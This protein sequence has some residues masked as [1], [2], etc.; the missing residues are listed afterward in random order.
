M[1]I[2][3]L[4]HLDLRSVSELRNAILHKTS[5]GSATHAAGKIIYDSGAVYVSDGS[6]WFDLSGDI[7]QVKVIG[8]DGN[9]NA[10]DVTSGNFVLTIAGASGITT[11][12]S[13]STLSI[14]L[15]DTATDMTATNS[16]VYGSST[17][18][19]VITVDR[20][21]RLTN[22]TTTSIS[23]SFT[24]KDDDD[25][26][27]V[28][29]MGKEIKFLG[30]GI[31]IDWT[32]T[33]AGTD[34]DPYD[35]TFT[36]SDKGSS[37]NIFKTVAIN[38]SHSGTLTY[39]STRNLEAD[40]NN[41]TLKVFDGDGIDVTGAS[42]DDIMKIAVDST[43]VRTSG[44]QT[45]AGDKTFSDEVIINGNLTV[46]GTQTTKASETVLIE[47]NIITL[48]SNETSAA[49]ENAGI[50]VERGSDTNVLLRWTEGTDRWQFTND[51]STYYNIPIPSEYDN[52]SFSVNA[53]NG[54]GQSTTQEVA[55]GGTLSFQA[56]VVDATDGIQLIISGD[57]KITVKHA[58]TS[59]QASVN[60]TG[61]TY[62]QDITLDTYGHI[63]AI[64][65]ATETVTD[66]NTQL[67]TKSALID[68]SVMDDTATHRAATI[69]HSMDSAKVMVQLFDV[70]TGG[71]VF[72][73][74]VHVD[75]DTV[76]ITF[77]SIPTNDIRVLMVDLK[78]SL[79]DITPTYSNS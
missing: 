68:V 52:F 75:K 10:Y 17:A 57:D 70:T 60:N 67:V 29:D 26:D 15:D 2:P 36:N 31:G 1:A 54:G 3:I 62:I 74:I 30:D 18:I 22:A 28:I 21:G 9:D 47:D 23:T 46:S 64:T 19:P 73:D 78:D 32:D 63:T 65:S 33:S 20:Q 55:N 13:S 59:G 71:V 34:G 53:T 38:P 69:D 58:N 42:Q 61:R 4:N 8:D 37:Q 12:I 5:T 43:V 50:E 39:A 11:S 76:K 16:G 24:I 7:K 79:S 44:A 56:G 41:D 48:N 49:S 77:A 35:L 72:A 40:S 66:T 14:D 6:A 51:G 45:I 25:D 27:L